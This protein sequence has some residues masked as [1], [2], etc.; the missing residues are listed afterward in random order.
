MLG[1]APGRRPADPLNSGVQEYN[2]DLIIIIDSNG[3]HWV[4]EVAAP[5]ALLS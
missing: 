5:G 4:V 3:T 2:P 1:Q